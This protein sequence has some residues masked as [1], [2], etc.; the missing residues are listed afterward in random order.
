MSVCVCMYR[1]VKNSSAFTTRKHA[2]I[3]C[4]VCVCVRVCVFET[5]RGRVLQ[6]F[7]GPLMNLDLWLE[8]GYPQGFKADVFF[9]RNNSSHNRK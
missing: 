4:V 8:V 2:E 6:D 3:C 7:M 5:G 1:H 9:E